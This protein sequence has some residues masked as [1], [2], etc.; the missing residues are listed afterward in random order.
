VLDNCGDL[1]VVQE[2]RA[3]SL[4]LDPDLPAPGRARR[5]AHRHGW[6]DLRSL[7]AQISTSGYTPLPLDLLQ[8]RRLASTG[9]TAPGWYPDP[10]GKDQLR[11]WDGEQWTQ[12]RQ[13]MGAFGDT[14]GN[15]TGT[16]TKPSSSRRWKTWQLA[17]ASTVALLLGVVIG[18]AGTSSD[19]VADV[20]SGPTSSTTDEETTTTARA[21]EEEPVA[22]TPPATS[23]PATA[24]PTTADPG[25]ATSFGSGTYQAGVDIEAGTY[26]TPNEGSTFCYVDVR[27][28]IG[29]DAEFIDQQVGEGPKIIQVA[30]GLFVNSSDCGTWSLS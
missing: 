30:E 10:E 2:T 24:P 12:D 13:P 3:P 23:P 6:P 29:S 14:P 1:R 18:G 25:P 17:A 4:V 28:G 7:S 20:A 22:T 27:D 11:W 16:P 5:N 19:D 21:T 26:R 15:P 9:M 8:G